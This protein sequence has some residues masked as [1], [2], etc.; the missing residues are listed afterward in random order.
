MGYIRVCDLCGKP[1]YEVG[2]E[3]KIKEQWHAWPGDS[4]WTNITCH[5]DC[6]KKLLSGVD[7]SGKWNDIGSLSCRCSKCGCK[8]NRQTP[9]CPICGKKMR[10]PLMINAAQELHPL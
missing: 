10:N 1:L 5:D 9:Y 6:V 8:N 7:D 4:G 3:F 2:R